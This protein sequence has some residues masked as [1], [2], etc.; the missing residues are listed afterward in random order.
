MTINSDLVR[1]EEVTSVLSPSDGVSLEV[2]I[3]DAE[4]AGYEVLE[5]DRANNTAT[6]TWYRRT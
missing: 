4:L 6:I 3:A 1:L 2:A 5:I